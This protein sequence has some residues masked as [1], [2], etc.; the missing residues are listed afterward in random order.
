VAI[1]PVGSVFGACAVAYALSLAGALL[2]AMFP[3]MPAYAPPDLLL[4]LIAVNL[5]WRQAR[6]TAAAM[7]EL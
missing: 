7:V 5:T 1:A 2:S 4:V 3:S 6:T